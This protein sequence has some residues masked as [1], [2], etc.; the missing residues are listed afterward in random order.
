MLTAASASAVIG[1]LALLTDKGH[2]VSSCQRVCSVASHYRSPSGACALRRS[3]AVR[4]T[5]RTSKDA[6][7]ALLQSVG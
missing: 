2:R 3:A 5:D 6:Y 1:V 7:I 4:A